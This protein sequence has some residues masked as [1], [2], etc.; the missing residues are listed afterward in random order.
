[1]TA[2]EWSARFPE[3]EGELRESLETLLLLREAVRDLSLSWGCGQVAHA[4]CGAT[5]GRSADGFLVAV[6]ASGVGECAQGLTQESD[7]AR[8]GL[9]GFELDLD[10]VGEGDGLSLALEVQ[11]DDGALEGG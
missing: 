6:D 5:R 10:G 2:E 7:D 3:L 1:M 9:A 8:I 4:L 11:S